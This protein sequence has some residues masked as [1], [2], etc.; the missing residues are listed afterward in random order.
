MENRDFNFN[1]PTRK[2]WDLS[3]ARVFCTIRDN[4]NPPTRKGWDLRRIP[5]AVLH[6]PISI[7]PPARG[8]TECVCTRHVFESD[9]NPPTR[10]GWDLEGKLRSI[11]HRDFNPPTRKGWD[12]PADARI[13]QVRQISIHPPARGGTALPPGGP[14]AAPDFNPP[15]RKG[16]DQFRPAHRGGA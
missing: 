2:G 8:G 3:T 10:K 9:F 14:R 13:E 7:H 16:W 15:T 4:F 6:Y 11:R 12:Q 1:P 5:C